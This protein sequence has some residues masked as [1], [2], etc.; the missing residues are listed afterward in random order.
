MEA[1]QGVCSLEVSSTQFLRRESFR[2]ECQSFPRS[3]PPTGGSL[4]L[5]GPLPRPLLWSVPPKLLPGQRPRRA[6]RSGRAPTLSLSHSGPHCLPT[7]ASRARKRHVYPRDGFTAVGTLPRAAARGRPP[8]PG[9]GRALFLR[10][11]CLLYAGNTWQE[12]SRLRLRWQRLRFQWPS[13]SAIST[14]YIP[15]AS[16]NPAPAPTEV[17]PWQM[18]SDPMTILCQLAWSLNPEEWPWPGASRAGVSGL[19]CAQAFGH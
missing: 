3:L 15:A 1:M 6:R 18:G 19:R 8:C 2:G 5:P 4:S 7:A 11:L 10:T 16:P 9:P 14:P 13:W 17:P 12:A